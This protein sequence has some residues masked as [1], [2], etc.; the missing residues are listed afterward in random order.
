MLKWIFFDIGGT[1]V[2]ETHS[3][4][5]RVLETIKI[6][7]KLG[8]HYTIAQ[9][10]TEMRRSALAGRSYFRGAMKTLGLSDYT[11]YDGVGE[12]LYPEV[13]AVLAALSKR[14]K[15]GII[16]NQPLGTETRLREYGIR[17]Y[18]SVVLSSAEEGMEKPE[19]ALFLRALGRADCRPEEAMMIGDRPDNDVK[20]AK[21]LGMQTVRITQGF[22]GMMPVFDES[23]Q[24][25]VTISNLG[26]LLGML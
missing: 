15:L 10:E 9:L 4:R 5:L 21:A 8:N 7:E 11:P 20:P 13:K 25:D 23:M 18:F 26:E 2:N 17:D 12:Y 22:G 14:Y 3:F 24:A 16:A 19:K 6:Q 1:L